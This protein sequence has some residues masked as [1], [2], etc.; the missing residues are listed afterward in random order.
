VECPICGITGHLS[1]EGNNVKVNFSKGEQN[2]ARG[3]ATGL[4]EHYDEIG[5]MKVVAIPKLM[6][7]KDTLPKMLEK[8]RDFDKLV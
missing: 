2:H 1:I 4:Q 6:A 8:Y 7:T 3:T 5:N